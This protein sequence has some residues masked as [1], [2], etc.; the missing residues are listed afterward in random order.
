MQ[1]LSE[2]MGETDDKLRKNVSGTVTPELHAKLEAFMEAAKGLEGL[3]VRGM[4]SAVARLLETAE[5]LGWIDDAENFRR[6]YLAALAKSYE[7]A[8]KKK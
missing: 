1:I 8:S 2:L 3:H 4:S 6:V 5:L 7:K